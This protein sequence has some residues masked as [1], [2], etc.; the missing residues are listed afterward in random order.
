M[1][2]PLQ[3]VQ[4][5]A[6]DKSPPKVSGYLGE[7]ITLPSGVDPS[8]S[9]IKI[10]W[11][12]FTNITLIAT[13][14]NGKINTDRVPQYTGRLT[15]NTT[16]GDLT[17]H[18]LKER[19]AIE[20]T[21]EVFNSEGKR[22]TNQIKITAK[23]KLQQPSIQIVTST[24]VESGCLMV[25]NCSSLDKGVNL[26]WGVEPASVLTINKS[27]PSD[28][29]AQLFAFVN[30]KENF[31]SFTCI[32][33][34]DTE[35]VS[36]KPVTPKCESKICDSN[37]TTPPSPT[38]ET[39][40]CA[41]KIVIWVFATFGICGIIFY[42]IYRY[43]V[44]SYS[45]Q[46]DLS[47]ITQTVVTLVQRRRGAQRRTDNPGEALQNQEDQVNLQIQEAISENDVSSR[48]PASAVAVQRQTEEEQKR[49]QNEDSNK[50]ASQQK[51]TIQHKEEN[52]ELEQEHEEQV[53]RMSQQPQQ[54]FL[55]ECED[56]TEDKWQ[57]TIVFD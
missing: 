52:R 45:P 35:S 13:Y 5:E 30:T 22:K 28:S 40:Y 2:H 42:M 34:R 48:C 38:T 3:V 18:N 41:G 7:N 19:D 49:N 23:Q 8:W 29:S 20:Y 44:Q 37:C 33:S 47:C 54:E 36:S 9:L 1:S 55:N 4:T 51:E 46:G 11:S 6:V 10:E 57:T 27:H 32:S 25:V 31:A 15:L 56:M 21:V 24:S 50:R 53:S 26:S 14:R 16:S 43:R 39:Q 12:I 17:I